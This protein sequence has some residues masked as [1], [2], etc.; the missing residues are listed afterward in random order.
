M[1][2]SQ[3]EPDNFNWHDAEIKKISYEDEDMIWKVDALNVLSSNSQNQKEF[4]CCISRADVVFKKY[5]IKSI[6]KYGFKEYQ[7]GKLLEEQPDKVFSPEEIA[8]LLAELSEDTN[9]T[10]VR[11]IY[12]VES[13]MDE[14]GLHISCEVNL[15][16]GEAGDVCCEILCDELIVKWDEFLGKP[17][18]YSVKDKL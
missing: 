4:D 7:Y 15:M 11:Y 18:Y 17:W 2:V 10:Y 14:Q 8:K 12:A 1:Y 13:Y 6:K 9:E 5:S 3:N 16:T